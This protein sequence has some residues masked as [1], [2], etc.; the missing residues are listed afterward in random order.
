MKKIKIKPLLPT[1]REK[2]RYVV[3]EVISKTPLD[4]NDVYAS[5]TQVMLA[6]IGAFGMAG[7]GILYIKDKYKNNRGIVRCNNRFVDHVRASFALLTHIQGTPAM[8]RSVG[9][10]GILKKALKYIPR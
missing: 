9:T 3:F 7:G 1:L 4:A 5:I 6:F 8:V 2:K 10:S